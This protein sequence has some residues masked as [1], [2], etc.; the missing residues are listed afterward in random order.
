MKVSVV[1]PVYNECWTIREIVR[2][3]LAQAGMLHELIMVDDGS[4]DGTREFIAQLAEKHKDGPVAVRAIYRPENGGKGC[5]LHDGFAAVTGDVVIVQ[6]ADLEYDPQDYGALV[7][8]IAEGR[9]DAVFGSRFLGGKRNMLLF[10][11]TLANKILTLLCNVVSNLNYSDV[12]TGYKVFRTEIIRKVPLTARGFDF[13]PEIAIKL[14]KLGCRISEVP[15]SY[16]GRGYA[17]GKKIGFAD[18]LI[19]VWVIAKTAMAGDL[20]DLAI[21]EQTLRIMSKAGRYNRYI[22]ELYRRYLGPDVVEI[23]SGMGNISRFLLDRN[24]LLLTENDPAYIDTLRASFKD[25]EGIE[26]R[27]LDITAPKQAD[28]LWGRFDTAIC[29]NVIEHVEQDAR[30]VSNI[31]RLLKPGGQAVLIVPAHQWLHGALDR[32]LGHIKRY[33]RDGFNDLVTAAG[34]ELVESRYLNPIAV[35]GWFFNGRLL[36]RK[37]IPSLQLDLFDR[38]TWLVRWSSA[39]GLPFGLSLFTVARKPVAADG[40]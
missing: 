38:L 14:A 24:R 1:M 25:W 22:Y 9:A 3:V 29:F 23:G 31:A 39:F 40:R 7:E 5:A 10:W 13:E 20:G 12:W 18:A 34:L 30:A 21:G 35:P 32:S 15:V 27:P 8:P 4:T 33:D 16:H 2:R 26:I 36:R 11:H 28:A 17:E 6:D 19:A 37:I